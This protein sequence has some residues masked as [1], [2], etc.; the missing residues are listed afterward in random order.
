MPQHSSKKVK[1]E[2]MA[3]PITLNKLRYS[4]RKFQIIIIIYI[5]T[6]SIW[7]RSRLI[8][9]LYSTNFTEV[10]IRFICPE[11]VLSQTILSL[12]WRNQVFNLR[13][14]TEFSVVI[15]VNIVKLD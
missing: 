11:P 14:Y 3:T 8:E 15:Y 7:I 1:K 6:V 10:V 13:N 9:A 12:H 5:I 2:E 4:Y